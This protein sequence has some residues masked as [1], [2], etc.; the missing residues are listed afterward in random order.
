MSSMNNR[1]FSKND[2]FLIDCIERH[3]APSLRESISTTK[4]E[5]SLFRTLTKCLLFLQPLTCRTVGTCVERPVS[6][7]LLVSVSRCDASVLGPCQLTIQIQIQ[8][9]GVFVAVND[10]HRHRLPY[11]SW[12][13]IPGLHHSGSPDDSLFSLFFLAANISSLVSQSQR[14]HLHKNNHH[15]THHSSCLHH[16]WATPGFF[17]FGGRAKGIVGAATSNRAYVLSI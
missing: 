5:Q 8:S 3:L 2:P 12:Y 10:R 6:L 17:L 11:V 16:P 15:L 7:I 13:K 14:P 9:S 4:L 1:E